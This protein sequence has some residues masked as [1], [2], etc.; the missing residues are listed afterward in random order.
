MS[1]NPDLLSV[2]KALADEADQSRSFDSWEELRAAQARGFGFG[3]D[4]PRAGE[5]SVWDPDV[6]PYTERRG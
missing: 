1:E 3:R 2:L 5:F 4:H 6:L